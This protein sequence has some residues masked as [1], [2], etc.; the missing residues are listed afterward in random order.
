[1]KLALR[2]LAP[3]VV[4]ALFSG[5]RTVPNK[6]GPPIAVPE[7]MTRQA[8]EV[9]LILAIAGRPPPSSLVLE[10][11]ISDVEIL[12]LLS[13]TR[14]SSRPRHQWSFESRGSGQVFAEFEHRQHY[15][16]V[17]AEYDEHEVTLRIVDS[18][19]L[20]YTTNLDQTAS[21][22]HENAIEWLQRFEIRVRRA[23]GQVALL[24]NQSSP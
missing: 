6:S 20:A 18:R 7:G 12:D 2:L 14:S 10:Q 19:N 15:M 4:V 22:I 9:A 1:M 24:Q 13:N 8:V 16:R 11:P 23:L 17:L 21:W 5:C 3:L